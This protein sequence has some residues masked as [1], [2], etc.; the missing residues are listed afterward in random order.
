MRKSFKTFPWTAH[1]SRFFCLLWGKTAIRLLKM[2][3]I[4]DLRQMMLLSQHLDALDMSVASTAVRH[5]PVAMKLCEIV[6]CVQAAPG[7]D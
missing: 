6:A 1:N 4:R 2:T 7:C 3:L 5:S